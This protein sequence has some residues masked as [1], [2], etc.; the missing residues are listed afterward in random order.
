[1]TCLQGYD[2]IRRIKGYEA[3]FY[4]TNNSWY[5]G[6]PFCH[7]LTAFQSADSLFVTYL[8]HFKV[9]SLFFTYLPHFKDADL[10]LQLLFLFVENRP[11]PQGVGHLH[12]QGRNSLVVGFERSVSRTGSPQ[13]EGGNRPVNSRLAIRSRHYFWKRMVMREDSIQALFLSVVA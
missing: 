7:I 2:S 9:D 4:Q 10:D 3:C 11:F 8:P 12:Q 1:M 5:L 6:Q 13:D